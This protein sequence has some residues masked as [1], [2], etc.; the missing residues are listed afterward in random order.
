MN[1]ATL[2]TNPI[3][4]SGGMYANDYANEHPVEEERR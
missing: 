3:H 4:W 2:D 1:M